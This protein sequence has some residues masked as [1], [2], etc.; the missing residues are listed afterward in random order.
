MRLQALMAAAAALSLAGPCLAGTVQESATGAMSLSVKYDDL[1]LKS[2]HGAA[3]LVIRVHDAADRVCRA[4]APSGPV[5][6][7]RVQTYAECVSAAEFQAVSALNAPM[8][9][10]AFRDRAIT[11]LLAAR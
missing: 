11:Q 6:L 1:D 2:A 5:E 8:V 9:T 3:E 7:T 4:A 10:A